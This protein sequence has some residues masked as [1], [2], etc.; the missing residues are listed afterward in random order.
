MTR[1][2]AAF[3][4]HAASA[5]DT[6]AFI[7]LRG[8]TRENAVSKER[9]AEAG[10]TADTWAAM[11]DSGN[12][13]GFV[14]RHDGQL[15]G[16]CFGDRTTGEIVVLALLPP[17]EGVGA[18]KTLLELVMAELRAQGHARLFLGCSDDPASRSYGFYRHLGW[19]STGEKDHFGDEV[20]EFMFKPGQDG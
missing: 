14:C 16:Y 12:L 8:Q 9:L 17:F 20:L 2:P 11:I 5:D 6:T 1:Q 13:P 7:T 19:T 10:I 4:F 3:T 18:G 15:A